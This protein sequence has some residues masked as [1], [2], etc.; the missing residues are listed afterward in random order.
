MKK[1]K[2]FQ[3]QGNSKRI[4]CELGNFKEISGFPKIQRIFEDP[5]KTKGF[6]QDFY[7]IYTM[8]NGHRRIP[9]KGNPI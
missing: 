7:T 5:R 8:K 6:S 3:A 4:S 9:G 2:I 1:L